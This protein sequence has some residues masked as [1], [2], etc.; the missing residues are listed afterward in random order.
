MVV[1][2]GSSWSSVFGSDTRNTRQILNTILKRLITETDMRDMYSLADPETCKKYIIFGSKAFSKLF[3]TV[4]LNKSKEG[5]LFFQQLRGIQEQHPDPQEQQANCQKL[6]FFFVRIFQIYAAIAITIIDS[7][8]PPIDVSNYSIPQ[9][10]YRAGVQFFNPQTGFKGFSKNT[11]S[12]M[13]GRQGVIQPPPIAAAGGGVRQYGGELKTGEFVLTKK[14][15]SY[16]NKFLIAPTSPN[17][18]NY[19]SILLTMKGPDN[20]FILIPYTS[21]Y[22]PPRPP[23]P[24]NGEAP[25]STL[26]ITQKDDYSGGIEFAFI[27]SD[28]TRLEGSFTLEETDEGAPIY[29]T[30]RGVSFGE[31]AVKI[32]PIGLSLRGEILTGAGGKLFP[33][34]FADTLKDLFVEKTKVFS[35]ENLLKTT[36]EVIENIFVNS[37]VKF[38]STKEGKPNT[39][40][41][42]YQPVEAMK[43]GD[44]KEKVRVALEV[45]MNPLAKVQGRFAYNVIVDLESAQST[46]GEIQ[47]FIGEYMNRKQRQKEQTFYTDNINL[48]K[49][50]LQ[51]TIGVYIQQTLKSII[52]TKGLAK[53]KEA[54]DLRSD[55][56]YTSRGMPEPPGGR[57]ITPELNIKDIWKAL[58]KNPPVKPHCM[59]RAL[60]LLNLGA[61]NGEMSGAFSRV[62]N[63]KFTLIKDG[64]LPIPGQSIAQSAG[65]KA[66]AMLFMNAIDTS[67]DKIKGSE[68]YANFRIRFKEYFEKYQEGV[69][70]PAD[71]QKIGAVVEKVMPFCRGHENDT[72]ILD[73]DMAYQLRSKV[74]ELR[75]RQAQHLSRSMGILFQLFDERAVRA[76]QFELS[77]YVWSEGTDALAYITVQ[78]RDLLMEYYGDCEKTYKEGLFILYNKYKERV[79]TG[80]KTENAFSFQAAT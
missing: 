56:A 32:E 30:L 64:S 43:F 35:A 27:M 20:S 19:E 46:P 8:L 14:P 55:I 79:D 50:K 16:L 17:V 52:E 42:S 57:G 80:K 63:T 25:T 38:I 31:K 61:I 59:A 47:Y 70:S 21:L 2:M 37:E 44:V 6:A 78:A 22:N 62:C 48:P 34:I 72:I 75:N 40:L 77:E 1:S 13:F 36:R 51:R 54:Y 68:Q 76:G 73:S 4:K 3:M 9:S 58:A 60:Q 26:R 29:L 10:S 12:Y 66:L 69:E 23:E 11:S 5:T 39:I 41:V 49:D 53:D 15:Y 67:A 74:N 7:D 33:A 65:I 71:P 28:S 45:T 18:E 24:A